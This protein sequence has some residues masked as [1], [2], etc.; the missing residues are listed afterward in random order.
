METDSRH[1]NNLDDLTT[2]TC[3]ITLDIP[4]CIF[5]RSGKIDIYSPDGNR[6][7]SIGYGIK[8]DKVEGSAYRLKEQIYVLECLLGNLN[9]NLEL[10]AQAVS[11]LVDLL[12]RMQRFCRSISIDVIEA[13]IWP[14]FFENKLEMSL[15]Q[16]IVIIIFNDF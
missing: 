2:D 4:Q 13:A 5:Y 10:S 8:R 16:L 9:N 15:K 3:R 7:E 12:Y 14:P 6:L 11:A 1:P